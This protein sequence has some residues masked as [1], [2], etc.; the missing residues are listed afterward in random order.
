MKIV[1]HFDFIENLMLVGTYQNVEVATRCKIDAHD[2][3]ILNLGHRIVHHVL[4]IS[5]RTDDNLRVVEDVGIKWPP[6]RSQL[7]TV[8][9][10]V[11]LRAFGGVK[12]LP[13]HEL[14]LVPDRSNAENLARLAITIAAFE[15]DS[16]FDDDITTDL[17][18]SVAVVL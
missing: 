6:E 8:C 13:A 4:L 2:S 12:N 15:F 18:Q 10:P 11:V 17:Y 1:L 14:L 5:K 3:S 9:A 16:L 7:A